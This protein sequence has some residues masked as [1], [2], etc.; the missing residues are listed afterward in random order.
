MFEK[1]NNVIKKF[2]FASYEIFRFGF[3]FLP[4]YVDETFANAK[5]K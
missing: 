1:Q 3:F 4:T 5:T 2:N